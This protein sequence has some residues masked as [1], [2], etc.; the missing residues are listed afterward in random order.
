MP[1]IDVLIPFVVQFASQSVCS[2]EWLA[3]VDRHVVLLLFNA[4]HLV[5]A[6]APVV[7]AQS[8]APVIIKIFDFIVLLL[9]V[10]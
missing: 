8:T 3:V 7:I 2:T 5:T 4:T 9:F 1:L 6:W 10:F